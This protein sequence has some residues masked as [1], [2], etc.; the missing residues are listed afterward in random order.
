MSDHSRPQGAG[1]VFFRQARVALNGHPFVIVKFRTMVVDA[2]RLLAERMATKMAKPATHRSW[3]V[4]AM[5][6]PPRAQVAAEWWSVMS[7]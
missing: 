2:E 4:L 1:P 6:E 5:L 7:W 3:L